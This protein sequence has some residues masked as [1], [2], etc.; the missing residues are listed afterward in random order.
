MKTKITIKQLQKDIKALEERRAREIRILEADIAEWKGK[1]LDLKKDIG[2]KDTY[3]VGVENARIAAC[4]NQITNLFEIIRWQINPETAKT[5][6][7]SD[8]PVKN[9]NRFN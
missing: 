3:T 7:E 2:Y 1:Y 4:Q 9:T 6:F 8:S 5:P